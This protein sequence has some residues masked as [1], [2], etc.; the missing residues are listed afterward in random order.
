MRLIRFVLIFFLLMNGLLFRATA[1]ESNYSNY[2]VGSKATMLG[3]S[4]TVGVDNISSIYYNPGALSFIENSSV[5]LETA[6]LFGGSLRIENGAGQDIDIKSSFL[7]VI[8]SL[9]GGIIKSKKAEDWTFG[10]AAITVNSSFIEFN[11]RNT[12]FIDVLSGSPGPEL[13]EGIYDY[14]NKIRENWIGTA[15]SRKVNE[16]FAIGLSVFGVYFSQ[17]YNLRQSALVSDV[18]GDS[19]ALSLAHS[20]IQRDLRFRSAGLIVKLGAVYKFAKSQL[21]LT[22]TTPTLNLDVFAKGDVSQT[23]AV[24][25]PGV[26]IPPKTFN[27]YGGDLTTYHRTPMVISLGYQMNFLNAQWSMSAGFYSSVSEYVMLATNPQIFTDP[28]LTKPSLKVY[29]E[30]QQVI[31][32]AVGMRKDIRLGLSLLAGLKT[33]FNYSSTEFLDSDR[34]IPKMSYWDLYH[35]TGGVIWYTEKA[36]LTLGAD[37]AFGIS[38]GDLQQVN[39]SHPTEANGLF[40]VKTNDTRTFLNQLNIVLGFSYSF[41]DIK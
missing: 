23:I 9:I 35:V 4:V 40:G 15:A 26:G 3:G 38:N 24:F 32:L 31:N 11:V 18:V 10:Y 33:D 27:L 41:N 19:I 36:H 2:E 7:D 6:T 8:P 34:F 28:E 1:Q 30:A 17:N 13:Y 5:S 29:D 12:A 39:L 37:Y 20:T 25:N 16:N 21:G 14:N 22:L